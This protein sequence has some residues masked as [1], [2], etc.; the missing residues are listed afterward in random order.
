MI[1]EIQPAIN[2]LNLE[3]MMKRVK[4]YEALREDTNR[5]EPKVIYLAGEEG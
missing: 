3:H 5:L 2:P 4:A 1:K